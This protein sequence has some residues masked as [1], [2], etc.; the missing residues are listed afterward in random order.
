MELGIVLG[1][2]D[3]GHVLSYEQFKTVL[4]LCGKGFDPRK[5]SIDIYATKVNC[6]KPWGPHKG[7]N[8]CKWKVDGNPPE[9]ETRIKEFNSVIY[10]KGQATSSICLTFAKRIIAERKDIKVT[11]V[12]FSKYISKD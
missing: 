7:H 3:S 11:W 1:K 4:G 12:K 5:S 10:Q 9:I 6:V 8:G 2:D